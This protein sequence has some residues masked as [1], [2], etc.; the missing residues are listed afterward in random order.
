[1][2]LVVIW[3]RVCLYELPLRVRH[4]AMYHDDVRH[5]KHDLLVNAKWPLLREWWLRMG[6]KVR[7]GSLAYLRFGLRKLVESVISC[8]KYQRICGYFP[9]ASRNEDERRSTTVNPGRYSATRR[10]KTKI[11]GDGSG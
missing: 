3:N 2:R 1:M 4:V 7:D 5:G 9:C 8:V 11:I 6:V 10:A